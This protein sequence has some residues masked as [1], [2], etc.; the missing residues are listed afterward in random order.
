MIN[1]RSLVVVNKALL[2]AVAG[3]TAIAIAVGVM[4]TTGL[5]PGFMQMQSPM[6]GQG[7]MAPSTPPVTQEKVILSLTSVKIK[8]IDEDGVTIDVVF[9]VFNPNENTLV[10]ETIEYDLMAN[11]ITL[12]RSEIGERLQGVVTGT[13]NTYYLVSEL[14]LTLKDTVQLN[15][16]EIFAPI[17]SSLQGGDVDWR[18]KGVYIITDPVRLG[19]QENEFDF[20]L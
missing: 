18:I 3:G 17:W 14:P 20:T 2:G 5:F 19:G 12:K 6:G 15:K 13:G 16:G 7:G 11:G 10:L 8:E 4:F 9:D 1:E